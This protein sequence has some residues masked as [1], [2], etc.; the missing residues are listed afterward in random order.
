[1]LSFWIVSLRLG[2]D[3]VTLTEIAAQCITLTV[4]QMC[5]GVIGNSRPD[6]SR[7]EHTIKLVTPPR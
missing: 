7:H 3:G 5:Y 4:V 2:N 1:M 6:L